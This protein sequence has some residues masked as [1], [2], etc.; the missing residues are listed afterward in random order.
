MPPT[1]GWLEA[2]ET[3]MKP[4]EAGVYPNFTDAD[5]DMESAFPAP[6]VERLRAAKRKYDPENLFHANHPVVSG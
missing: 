2:I 4:W 6:T 3:A 5:I 1:K